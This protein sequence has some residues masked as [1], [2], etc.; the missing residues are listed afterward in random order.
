M[1]GEVKGVTYLDPGEGLKDATAYYYCV[2]AVDRMGN[3]QHEG[4]Q[5]V[6]CISDHG[7]GVPAL[8]SPT[9]SGEEWSSNSLA[10]M[11]WDAPADVTGIAGYY[12][13]LDQS[14]SSRPPL[15][16][17]AFTDVRRLE[18][19]DLQSGIWYFHVIAKDR[20]GNLSE[21]SAHY[22]LKIDVEKPA[23]PQ[24]VSLTHP[25]P[26]CW[27]ASSKIQFKLFAPV[28]LSGFDAFYYLFDQEPG[29]RPNP[30]DA[31]RTTEE[32]IGMR[33]PSPGVWYLHAT[34]RDKAG[35]L[36]EPAHAKVLT[37]AGEAPPPVISSPTH[38]REDEAVNQHHPVF[39]LEDRHDG[40]F[41]G[42]GVHYRFS[43]NE[44][45]KVT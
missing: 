18:L 24:V 39:R 23:P 11:M 31:Q 9:H 15:E 1:D 45:E 21:E 40:S 5:V 44:V 25:D 41:K 42:S 2:Q 38:P 34:V 10:V 19:N 30:A 37:A 8:S 16:E 26:E 12:T 17:Q 43:A 35:N 4:N 33:A 27:Y 13:L 7:V 28:K 6:V 20:A 29:T 22:R 32:E 3:E 36:S 14:P